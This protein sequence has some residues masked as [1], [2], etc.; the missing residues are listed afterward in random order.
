VFGN[1]HKL[2]PLPVEKKTMWQREMDCLLSVCEYI[3]ELFPSSQSLPDG[4]KLEVSAQFSCISQQIIFLN[5]CNHFL[6]NLY[7]YAIR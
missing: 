5:C 7:V 6:L 1:C 3:V 2:E 4:T